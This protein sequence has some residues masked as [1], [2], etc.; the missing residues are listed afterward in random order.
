ML[1]LRT[2]SALRSHLPSPRVLTAYRG[3]AALAVTAIVALRRPRLTAAQLETLGTAAR[4]TGDRDLKIAVA[5]APWSHAAMATCVA[6]QAEIDRS[7]ELG[8]LVTAQ[9]QTDEIVIEVR[10]P[11]EVEWTDEQIS[12]HRDRVTLE[13]S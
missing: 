1:S 10:G 11:D 9:A 12:E 5:L 3:L 13:R 2:L 6:K 8:R 7:V 4:I